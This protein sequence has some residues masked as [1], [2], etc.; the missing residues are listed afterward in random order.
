MA[1]QNSVTSSERLPGPP[2]RRSVGYAKNELDFLKRSAQESMNSTTLPAAAATPGV[3]PTYT[4]ASG[5]GAPDAASSGS[6]SIL[7]LAMPPSLPLAPKLSTEG[8]AAPKAEP[9]AM[10]T[11]VQPSGRKRLPSWQASP[12]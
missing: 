11:D 7:A 6:G 12:Y 3:D 10:E 2:P 5:A 1:S 8:P 9:S 4:T